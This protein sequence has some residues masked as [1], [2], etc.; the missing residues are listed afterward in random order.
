MIPSRCVQCIAW[1]I[2]TLGQLPRLLTPKLQLFKGT[3][4]SV[5]RRAAPPCTDAP[6][7]Y[8]APA[9]LSALALVGLGVGAVKATLPIPIPHP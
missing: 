6:T 8:C 4:R 7:R 2:F 9:V 1:A 5:G 3:V